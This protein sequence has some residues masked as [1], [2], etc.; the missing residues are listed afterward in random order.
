ME[1]TIKRRHFSI[2]VF[3]TLGEQNGV[4]QYTG[5]LRNISSRL[6]TTGWPPLRLAF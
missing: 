3:N 5:C 1:L 6:W 4:R 2:L